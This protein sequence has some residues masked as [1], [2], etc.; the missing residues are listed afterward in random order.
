MAGPKGEDKKGV[1][2]VQMNADG[3]KTNKSGCKDCFHYD[4]KGVVAFLTNAKGTKTNKSGC[5]DCF[6]CGATI[7]WVGDCPLLS[8]GKRAKVLVAM[9]TSTYRALTKEQQQENRRAKPG[10]NMMIDGG[11]GNEGSEEIAPGE[12]ELAEATFLQR[13]A[14]DPRLVE[15]RRTLNPDRLYL[16]TCSSFHMCFTKKHMRQIV[17]VSK[18]LSGDC[19]TGTKHS[20]QK[21]SIGR[22]FH[23]WLVEN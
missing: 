21:G 13:E 16:D 14:E 8:H 3:T 22:L 5:K 15:V 10:T 9:R 4:E 7:H 23:V 12:G 6:H 18:K 19:K 2:A 1:V 17:E 11:G 20:S